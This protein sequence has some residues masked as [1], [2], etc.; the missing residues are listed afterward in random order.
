VPIERGLDNPSLDAAAASMN[1][2]DLSKARA[3]SSL[4]ISVDD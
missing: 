1:H 2:P 3:G 4:D